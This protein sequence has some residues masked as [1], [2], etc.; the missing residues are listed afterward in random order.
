MG[1]REKIVELTG[2]YIRGKP[3]R[4][5]RPGVD[6][7]PYADATLGEREICSLVD[8]ALSGWLTLGPKGDVFEQKLKAVIGARDV[9]PVNSGSSANLAAFTSLCSN[10]MP[11]GERLHPGDEV[12]APATSFPTTVAPIIQNGL[13][14][15]YVDCELGNYNADIEKLEAAA[16]ASPKVRAIALS[17]TLG[18]VFDLDRVVAL[19]EKHDLYL[20]EDCCDALG[21]RWNGRSVGTFGDFSTLSF[22]PSH[23]ITTGE[24]GAV[25]TNNARFGR[26]ARS[27]R[28]WGRDCWCATGVSGTCGKRFGWQLGDL[29]AEYDHK[30]IYSTIGYNLKPTDL[31]AS[32]GLVQIDRLPDFVEKRKA[33]F[34]RLY[35]G[36]LGTDDLILPTWDKRADVSWF[37]FP[38]TVKMGAHFGRRE[39]VRFLEASKIDTRMLFAGNIVRQPGF[40]HAPHRVFSDLE[41]SDHVMNSTFMIGLHPGITFDMIDYMA[42]RIRNF[43]RNK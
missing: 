23:H 29:P 39:L 12:L 17:H 8:T 41:T 25:M 37:S 16:A 1:L 15:V 38:I 36:L 9:I 32:I 10:M 4:Q 28:D 34:L 24:G 5:W 7:I 20:V 3:P 33:N 21:S 31:Q 2:E 26:I 14:P 11:E 40:K 19:C 42:L 22:Y 43:I 35:E 30:Y 27:V 6:L 13:I 18:N